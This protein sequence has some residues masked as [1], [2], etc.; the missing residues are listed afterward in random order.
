VVKSGLHN[1]LGLVQ[2]AAQLD[3]ELRTAGFRVEISSE[4]LQLDQVKLRVRGTRVGP[5]HDGEVCD[6]S[7]E[8]AFWM[9]LHDASG[10]TVGIQA[11]RCDEISTSLADWLPSMMIGVYMRR[12]EIMMPAPSKH[13]KSS[14]A[15]RLSGCLV[16]E[17]E[18]WLSKEVKGKRIFDCFTRLGMLLSCIKWN[19]DAIWALTSE[20]MARHGHLGRIGFNTIERGFL[21]WQMASKDIDPVEYL[22]VIDRDGLKQL[23][24]E[25][26][27]TAAECPPQQTHTRRLQLANVQIRSDAAE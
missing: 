13:V 14:V 10:D 3:G 4:M 24:D 25:M 19:P 27:V 23:V 5:M 1:P 12:N 26:L 9:S 6:F 15:E 21:R 7:S 17:G 11:Y 22:A 18:L 20:Q 2:L 8:R 16:Y